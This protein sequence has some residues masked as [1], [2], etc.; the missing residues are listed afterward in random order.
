M[1]HI[2]SCIDVVLLLRCAIVCVDVEDDKECIVYAA[3]MI[4]VDMLAQNLFDFFKV[5]K[6]KCEFKK[7]KRVSL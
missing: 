7:I 3:I 5:D 4:Y 1:I 6:K 2:V